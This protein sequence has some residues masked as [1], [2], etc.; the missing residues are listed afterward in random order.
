MYTGLTAKLE[1]NQ[2]DSPAVIAYI[3]NW[4]VE[5]TRDIIEVTKLG[6]KAKEKKPSLYSWTASAEGTV[7][8]GTTSNQKAFRDAM[9]AGTPVSV[10]FYLDSTSSNEVKFTGSAY[11][12]SMSVDISAEDKG[13]ISISLNGDGELT[14]TAGASA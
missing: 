12:E 11:I 1:I 5:E 4:S 9:I 14:L 3:S 6:S 7:D 2:G 10:T 8:F 13:N